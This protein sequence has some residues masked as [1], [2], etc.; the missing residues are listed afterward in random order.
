MAE[1]AVKTER[2]QL[3]RPLSWLVDDVAK[4]EWK[5]VIAELE[6]ISIVGNLDVTNI[7][8]YC[9]AFSNYVK[10]SE[11]LKDQTYCIERE[12]RTGVMVVKN[13]M[14]EVQKNYADEMRKFASLCGLTID[15]RLKAGASKVEK[16]ENDIEMKFGAI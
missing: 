13:P 3:K 4:K 8:G 1:E 11:I 10:A 7:G 14:I 5:R 6:K 16:Q 12:T 15:S 9:N 2:N